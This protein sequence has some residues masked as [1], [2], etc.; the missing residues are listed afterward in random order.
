MKSVRDIN[1]ASKRVF[2]RVDYNVPMDDNLNITDDNRIFQTLDLIRYLLE[3]KAKIILASHMG[4]PKGKR[5]PK[6]SLA[7]ICNRLSLILKKQ[8][9]FADDCIGEAVINRVNQ[10]QD[11]QI[12]L[13]EN[14][15][16]HKAEEENDETFS[17][18]LADLCDV[19]VNDA[20]AVSH[21]DQASITGIPKFAKE[22]G[23]GFLLEKE[24][25][26]YYNSI[27][28]PKKPL[29]AI[30]GGAKVSSKLE[31]LEN[32][33]NFVDKLII[34]GAMANTFLKSQ[35][36][37]TKGSMI[38]EDFLL[39]AAGIVKKAKEKGVEFLLPMDLICADRFDKDAQ[40]K[41]GL[42]DQIP[43]KWM[44]LDIGPQTALK[45]AGAIKDAGTIVW[46]GPMGVFE[47]QQFMSGTKVVADAIAASSAF[48]IVGGGDTGLAAKKCNV[49]DKISYISTG[50]GAFLHLMEG[51]KLPGVVALE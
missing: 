50:G 4:R 31:A 48:S 43:D 33:L 47:I 39:T 3:Q 38:E 49:A 20:F 22:S 9:L 37:D 28:N 2:V 16:F 19:Y 46:N 29:V 13:L 17:N 14:L 15:R 34:G 6:L 42:V 8:V 18:K 25:Q 41:V 21:R 1:V 44:A 23:A 12:L 10:L 36:I 51:K 40:V 27:E 45:Y 7:P 24:V 30:I 5:D 35:G 26:S 32:L 11:G